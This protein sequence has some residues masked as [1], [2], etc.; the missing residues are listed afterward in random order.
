MLYERIDKWGTGEK[1]AAEYCKVDIAVD[2]NT[3]FFASLSFGELGSLFD[4]V[5][6][7]KSI[8]N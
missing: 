2:Q 4:I 7:R 6:V 3:T 8:W 5:N 1:E